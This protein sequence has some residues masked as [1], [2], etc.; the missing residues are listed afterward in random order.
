M[1]GANMDFGNIDCLKLFCTVACLRQK[2]YSEGNKLRCKHLSRKS[3]ISG[4]NGQCS[5]KSCNLCICCPCL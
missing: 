5:S 2:Q 3:S 1:K 4:W